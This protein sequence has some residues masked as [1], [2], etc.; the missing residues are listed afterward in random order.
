MVQT[1]SEEE[2]N[3]LKAWF[4]LDIQRQEGIMCIGK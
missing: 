1:S 4:E 3:I 2:E